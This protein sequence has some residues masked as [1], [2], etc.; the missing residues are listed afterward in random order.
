MTTPAPTYPTPPA[1]AEPRHER[2]ARRR[3]RLH[4][5][6][7]LLFGTLRL[8]GRHVRGFYAT[9]GLFL[10]IGAALAIAGTWAFAFLAG[11][12][13]AGS[14]QAFDDVVMRAVAERQSPAVQ[15]AMIE[16]TFLGT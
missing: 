9:V 14:T 12:V 2:R 5:F 10:T 11:H 15:Q 7:D 1:G 6:W 8:L 4:L 13:R 16:I 3:G